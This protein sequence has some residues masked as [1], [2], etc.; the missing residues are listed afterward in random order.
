MARIDTAGSMGTM[1]ARDPLDPLAAWMRARGR[2]GG[3]RAGC[4]Q[5]VED[6]GVPRCVRVCPRLSR[7]TTTSASVG[8]VRASACSCVHCS[9]VPPSPRSTPKSSG[10]SCPISGARSEAGS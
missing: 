9:C 6:G 7:A 1:A 10:T 4:R 2:E 5:G 8:K 3:G